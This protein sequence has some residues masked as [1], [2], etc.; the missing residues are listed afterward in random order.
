MELMSLQ[1]SGSQDSDTITKLYEELYASWLSIETSKIHQD[2]LRSNFER[3]ALVYVASIDGSSWRK[4]SECVWSTAAQLRDKVSLNIEYENLRGLFVDV[5]GAKQVTLKMAVEEL[6][7]AGRRESAD[8]EEVKASLQT[9]NSLL[10]SEPDQKEQAEFEESKILPVRYP[11]GAVRCVSAQTAFFI[12]DRESLR[13]QFEDKVKFLDFSLEEVNE[14]RPFLEWAGLENRYVTR[15]V[16]ESTSVGASDARPIS[17]PHREIRPRAHALLRYVYDTYVQGRIWV[18]ITVHRIAWHFQSPRVAT[19]KGSDDVYELLRNA[20]ILATDNIS[21]EYSLSQDGHSFKAQGDSI[22]IHLDEDGPNLKMY[23]PRKRDHQEHAFN[24]YLPERIVQWLMMDARTQIF[25][26]TSQEAINAATH[27]WNS[28]L[29]TLLKALDRCGIRNIDTPNLDA[30]VEDQSSDADSDNGEG[31]PIVETPPS[32]LD[33]TSHDSPGTYFLRNP[34][35]SSGTDSEVTNLPVRL[36]AHSRPAA[37]LEELL[38]RDPHYVSVLG[39]VIASARTSTIPD[40]NENQLII[41]VR[42]ISNISGSDQFE[43]DCKVGAARELFV[44]HFSPLLKSNL[45]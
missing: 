39:T 20:K 33:T 3:N 14:L 8:V 36:A 44:G 32:A 5:L 18:L 27:V 9:V 22:N 38:P 43:R 15:S 6:K 30:Y 41:A 45:T 40:R 19:K 26:A 12:V 25:Q 28:P 23:L 34:R 7:E 2:W 21:L 42:G 37:P 17:K 11:G 16:R 4:P 29:S 24:M 35:E 31:S 10:C 1:I 13:L